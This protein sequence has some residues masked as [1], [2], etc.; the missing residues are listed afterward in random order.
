MAIGKEPTITIQAMTNPYTEEILEQHGTGLKFVV[1]R[2]SHD[3]SEE[4]LVW[5]RDTKNRT[6]HIL[7][8]SKWEL[9]KED[10]LPVELKVGDD[11]SITK[12]EYHRIIKGE[13]DL[14]IR[15]PII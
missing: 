3:V 4:D 8:G 1:R 6:I 15:F 2:F 5:H 7:E 13:G 10:K 9:Q 11:Y 14:V 12:M